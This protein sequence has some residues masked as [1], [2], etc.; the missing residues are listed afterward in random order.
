MRG[1]GTF[2]TP[3]FEKVTTALP[4]SGYFPFLCVYV[5]LCSCESVNISWKS[6]DVTLKM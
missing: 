6:D 2:G 1:Y 5:T 3:G 4:D